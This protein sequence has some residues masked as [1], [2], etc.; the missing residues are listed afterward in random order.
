M[1]LSEAVYK[2]KEPTEGINYISQESKKLFLESLQDN[3]A[4]PF[5]ELSDQFTTQ[6]Y[7]SYCGP[8]NISIIL[9]SMGIDP[10]SIL[11]RNWKWYNEKNIHSCNIESVHDHGMPLTDMKFI[12]EKNKVETKL[13]RPFCEYNK[14]CLLQ[15]TDFD[16]NALSDKKKFENLFL[17]ED[18]TKFKYSTIKNIYLQ[19]AVETGENFSFYNLVDENFFRICIL[20]SNIYN[21]FYIV[22]NVHRGQLGQEGGG[23]F[24]PVMAYN[25]RSDYILLFD[26]ARY[27]Y[28]SRWHKV[29]T[30]FE[31][32]TGKDRVG[33]L[34]RGFIVAIKP[35]NKNKYLITKD[36]ILNINK[37][38]IE[39][40]L[41]KVK[42]DNI[43][44]KAEIFNWLIINEFEIDEQLLW[45]ER[46]DLWQSIIPN[47]Y[48]TNEKLKNLIDF[49]FMF[50][51][52][53]IKTLL[54][55][56]FLF[57]I[58]Q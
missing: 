34:S 28:N 20:A 12:F 14:S 21:N 36:K 55:G 15:K 54:L 2:I 3:T 47:M 8:T 7:G 32:L 17:Y 26:C 49:L 4:N 6:T 1:E 45:K 35:I 56:C 46:I 13:Y 9:N 37:Q 44:D 40:F 19:K 38:S 22:C 16:I 52:V 10:K 41:D 18:L 57:F 23:H 53:N 42:F 50:D 39:K 24:L 5:F 58:K 51:R 27:K 31:A 48:K 30:A 25:I 43:K 29:K 11:F 33:Q